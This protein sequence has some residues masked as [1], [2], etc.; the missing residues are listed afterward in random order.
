MCVQGIITFNEVIGKE[1]NMSLNFNEFVNMHKTEKTLKFK[2][3]PQ[4][5]TSDFMKEE[6]K[7]DHERAEA[8]PIVKELIDNV[9]RDIIEKALNYKNIEDAIENVKDVKKEK[10]L[11]KR[12]KNLKKLKKLWFEDLVEALSVKNSNEVEK[13]SKDIR[14]VLNMIINKD[15]RMKM[16]KGQ[17]IIDLISGNYQLNADEKNALLKFKKFTTYFTG[18]HKNRE[19]VFDTGGKTTSIYTRIVNENF[20]LFISGIGIVEKIVTENAEILTKAEARLHADGRINNENLEN[21]YLKVE[22]YI[23]FLT[24]DGIENFNTVVGAI[25]QEINLHNQQDKEGNKYKT[26]TKLKRQI[27]SDKE[28]PNFLVI[29]DDEQ[30]LKI[31]KDLHALYDS[32]IFNDIKNL[33]EALLK[34]CEYDFSKVYISG[35]F[36]RLL[37]QRVYSDQAYLID[38]IRDKIIEQ[39]TVESKKK[40]SK[41]AKKEINSYL[42]LNE[43][44][45]KQNKEKY[46]SLQ[47]LKDHLEEVDDFD[48][49]SEIQGNI[50]IRY[51]DAKCKVKKFNDEFR[52]INEKNVKSQDNV[53]IY[54]EALNKVQVLLKLT[55]HFN[56]INNSNID[57]DFYNEL[58]CIQEELE[59]NTNILNLVRNYVTKVDYSIEK[60]KLKLDQPTLA[61]GWSYS[62]EIDNKSIFLIKNGL[63]YLGIIKLKA[64]EKFD[65]NSITKSNLNNN[66]KKMNYY[67]WAGPNKMFPKCMFTNEVEQHFENSHSDYELFNEKFEKPFIVSNELFN[68]Y[69]DEHDGKKKFQKEYLKNTGDDVGHRRALGIAIDGCKEFLSAYKTTRMFDYSH[70]K[71]TE[72]YQD[73]REFYNDVEVASFKMELIEVD[74]NEVDKL[75]E[76]GKLLL[77]Q[78]YSKDFSSG[79]K[80]KDN[81]FTIY[82]KSLFSKE[83]LEVRNLRLN[84]GAEL[85]FRKKSIDNPVIHKKGVKVINKTY[86]EDGVTKSIP[87]EYVKEINEYFSGAQKNISE[88][89][90]VILENKNTVERELYYDIIKD[91]RFTVNQF[92]FHFPVTF[93]AN[94][95]EQNIDEKLQDKLKHADCNIIGIDRGERNL[96][97]VSVINSKGEILEQK[98]LNVINN[99]D[100]HEKL[101]TREKDRTNSRKTWTKIKGIKNLKEGYVSQAVHE[102]VKMAIGYNAIVAMENLNSGF[103]QSRKKFEKQIYQKFETMLA[104]KLSFLVFKDKKLEEAGSS[105]KAYQLAKND[106]NTIKRK[107]GI[108]FYVPAAY[109]SVIDIKTGFVN[110]FRFGSIKNQKQIHDFI[111][112]ID[113]IKYDEKLDSFVFDFNYKEF[114]TQFE[115]KKS[116][117]SV[118]TKGKRINTF[119]KNGIVKHEAVDLTEKMKEVI[120]KSGIKYEQGN[121]LL[122][123]II[124]DKDICKSIF[125][126]F[127]DTLDLRNSDEENDYILSPILNNGKFYD[128]RDKEENTPLDADANGAYNIAMKA[129]YAMERYKKSSNENK[130]I[131]MYIK[132]NEWID[133]VIDRGGK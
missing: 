125:Y 99:V 103:K 107:N 42:G 86:E 62:K 29:E 112:K 118:Y 59:T 85:F 19:N 67:L 123:E 25:N 2:L 52:H 18:F 68:T 84:G 90:K 1:D 21:D 106:V 31:I 55:K 57:T 117:W 37:S 34:D 58:R 10:S 120:N 74:A 49:I 56:V 26:L 101:D 16:I 51:E 66:Y 41:K 114:E 33:F 97:Y 77:F 70:L 115:I 95:C 23:K 113:S 11:K 98:S 109:T 3:L 63:Y 27:L 38:K 53:E 129:L 72:E 89:A 91:K 7:H 45:E 81:L 87:G 127:K 43:H 8:Y 93:N 132:H 65:F 60:I 61:D 71:L 80:G 92:E 12:E 47:E 124:T 4:G 9:Y 69:H 96:L 78:L 126:I 104:N 13:L 30:L 79:S 14:E 88:E 28:T 128:T 44:G 108:I 36:L 32:S 6:I 75:V 122:A 111:E 15:H 100:Y 20:P 110:I 17:K 46:F 35:G 116:K 40:L 105:L 76:D 130:N 39:K 83:N 54:R 121:N 22:N 82:L 48:L 50:D 131:D 64:G 5:K 94:I 133:F 24:Q 102:V 73:I 119:V